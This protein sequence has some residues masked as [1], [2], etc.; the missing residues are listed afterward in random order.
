LLA[1]VAASAS[2]EGLDELAVARPS[3]STSSEHHTMNVQGDAG[4]PVEGELAGATTP[5]LI[6]SVTGMISRFFPVN[7]YS[8][9]VR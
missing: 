9:N 1:S 6:G 5:G 7:Y 2:D 4:L 8:E 3:P